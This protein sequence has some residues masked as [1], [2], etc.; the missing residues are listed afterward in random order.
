M[1]RAAFFALLA[2]ATTTSAAGPALIPLHMPSGNVMQAEVMISDVDRARGV[3]FRDSLP[4]DRA[5]VFVFEDVD[6]HG[7]WMKNCRF[8]IDILW[9]DEQ[10]RVVHVVE[11]APP[12]KADPCPSYQP[13]RRAAYVVEMNAK[14]AKAQGAVVGS[15][16]RFT[17]P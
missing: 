16:V 5:L 14:Q 7:I 15:Q 2:M 1:R 3:M 17:L 4:R 12:C 6:F 9:L 13:M 8:P 10:Q 11:S